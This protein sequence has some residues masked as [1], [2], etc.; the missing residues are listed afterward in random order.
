MNVKI[1]RVRN[2]VIATLP[3]EAVKPDARLRA[4]LVELMDARDIKALLINLEEIRAMTDGLVSLILAVQHQAGLRD[5]KV[6]Y[7][8]LAHE[9]SDFLAESGILEILDISKTRVQALRPFL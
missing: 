3:A 8:N 7:F 2:T 5:L 6:V 1:E 4:N 9:V